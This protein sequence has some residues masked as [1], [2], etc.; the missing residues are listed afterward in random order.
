MSARTITE[1]NLPDVGARI[2]LRGRA[3]PHS[4]EEVVEASVT[5]ASKDLIAC[6]F[7]D[8]VSGKDRECVLHHRDDG[9]YQSFDRYVA[10][11]LSDAEAAGAELVVVVLTRQQAERLHGCAVID[12]EA[13]DDPDDPLREVIDSNEQILREA[14]AGK[15]QQKLD[16]RQKRR[17]ADWNALRAALRLAEPALAEG[18]EN[19]GGGDDNVYHAPLLAVRKAL[20]VAP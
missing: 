6:R 16:A 1:K 3:G 18:D 12:M 8:K 17:A 19:C 2:G 14:L 20:G 9:S 4:P 15:N 5:A 7:A 13:Q 11:Y 10:E